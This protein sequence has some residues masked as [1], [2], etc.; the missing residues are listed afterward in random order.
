MSHQEDAQKTNMGEVRLDS[1]SWVAKT[2]SLRRL[3]VP[4]D[5]FEQSG[6]DIARA[7]VPIRTGRRTLALGVPGADGF[8]LSG[9]CLVVRPR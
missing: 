8:V 9:R 4:T 5:C 3:Q 7:C 6:G 2:I 1:R